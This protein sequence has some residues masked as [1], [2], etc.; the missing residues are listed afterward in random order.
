MRVTERVFGNQVVIRI[1]CL[2]M[3][4]ENTL[5][6][7]KFKKSMYLL[8]IYTILTKCRK[9]KQHETSK[10]LLLNTFSAM[11]V[12][13]KKGLCFSAVLGLSTVL[14]LIIY[15][16]MEIFILTASLA[17]CNNINVRNLL[18]S[19]LSFLLYLLIL[20]FYV[21]KGANFYSFICYLIKKKKKKR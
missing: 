1:S 2:S 19:F 11:A 6:N 8:K 13:L 10:V 17:Q 18:N 21:K 14:I 12:H 15:Q 16:Q 4:L 7:N 5:L 3:E 20:K 9:I